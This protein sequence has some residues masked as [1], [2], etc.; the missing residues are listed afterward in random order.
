[1]LKPVAERYNK[2]SPDQR[3]Q[4]RRL[5]RAMIKWYGYIA[6]V[7]RMFDKDLHKEYVFLSDLIGLLPVDKTA[8]IDLEGKLKLDC[9]KLEKT[10]EG[11]I[12]VKALKDREIWVNITSTF[13]LKT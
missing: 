2:L 10:F 6:Q 4:F 8:M 5:R 7:A 12:Q 13:I 9:Y 3:Y 1:M 11:A